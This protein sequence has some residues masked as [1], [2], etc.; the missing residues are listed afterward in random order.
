MNTFIKRTNIGSLNANDICM[1]IN[2][3]LFRNVKLL[4]M[5]NFYNKLQD[6]NDDDDH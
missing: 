6:L 5:C 2:Y 3:I 1:F 4:I